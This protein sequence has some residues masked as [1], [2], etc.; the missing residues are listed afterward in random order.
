MNLKAEHWYVNQG[1]GVNFKAFYSI[2]IDVFCNFAK[3]PSNLVDVL[4]GSF[5]SYSLS[6]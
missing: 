4:K 5:R 3:W 1:V 6:I 2:G